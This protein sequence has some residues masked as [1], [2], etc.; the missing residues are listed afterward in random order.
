MKPSS[1]AVAFV[2]LA[3]LTT[4]CASSTEL[5]TPD[6]SA[7]HFTVLR[8]LHVE[9]PNP[10][11]LRWLGEDSLALVD[12]IEGLLRLDLAAGDS[13]PA[14]LPFTAGRASNAGPTVRLGLS[15]T[16][17]A[18]GQ[19]AF[20]LRWQERNEG[21]PAHSISVEYLADLDVRRD[22]ILLIGVRRDSKGRLSPEGAIVWR[23]ALSRDT[24]P[25]PVLRS[26]A[27]PGAQSMQDC[28]LVDLSQVRFL[29][30]GGFLVV[31]GVDPGIFLYDERSLLTRAWDTARLGID[32]GCPPHPEQQPSLGA[33]PA[34]RT[35]FL[36][37]RRV[38][39]EILDL[40]DGPA[41][42][43][44]RADG[45]GIA[46][47]LVQLD[48]ESERVDT[49]PFPI[50]GYGSGDRIKADVLR[51]RLA[52]LIAGEI[53]SGSEEARVVVLELVRR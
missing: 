16:H 10:S 3:L 9:L 30:D 46:W 17:L 51:D 33:D 28:A 4:A 44:R 29:A 15:D 19:S 40:P 37:S 48:A 13:S 1:E 45:D 52:V 38:V 8:E 36:S 26:A 50:R 23:A 22:Q 20:L 12:G 39:D 31:P 18:V 14:A 11:D 43:V 53:G 2:A 41:L 6:V 24:D 21:A 34:A 25:E 35:R 49:R 47:D 5:V 32:T 42:L 7:P 27:G